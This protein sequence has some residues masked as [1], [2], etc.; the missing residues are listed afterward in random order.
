[1]STWRVLA[2]GLFVPVADQP[3]DQPPRVRATEPVDLAACPQCNGAFVSVGESGYTCVG[4][5]SPPGHDHDDNCLTSYVVCENGHRTRFSVQRSC[6][7]CDW[8]GKPDCCNGD[9]PA[10][11]RE[12]P[13]VANPSP[14]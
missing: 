4:Y 12:W 2:S 11:I 8:R 14:P 13:P 5:E 7:A 10:K 1:M 9:M 6:P 3:A